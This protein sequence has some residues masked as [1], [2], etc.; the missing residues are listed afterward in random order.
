MD[1]MNES[2]FICL[3][4][5]KNEKE[6]SN[7]A[8]KAIKFGINHSEFREPDYNN[9]LTAVAFEPG[10]STKELMKKLKLAFT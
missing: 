3:L 7:L 5:V 6:L 9:S 8:I 4:Q 1:W 2:N 10:Q